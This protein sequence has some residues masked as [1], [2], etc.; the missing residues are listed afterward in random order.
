MSPTLLRDVSDNTTHE[1][2]QDRALLVACIDCSIQAWSAMAHTGVRWRRVD[3][4]RVLLP[5]AP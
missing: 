2:V 5:V 3:Y 1:R 4:F